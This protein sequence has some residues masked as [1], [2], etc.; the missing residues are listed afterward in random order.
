MARPR[1]DG[2]ALPAT[3]RER[4]TNLSIGRLKPEARP[5]LC[6]DTE[7]R[8]FAVSVQPTGSMSYKVIYSWRG[9]ARWYSIGLVANIPLADARKIAYGVLLQVANGID[10]AAVRKAGKKGE[11]FAELVDGYRVYAAARNKSAAQTDKKYVVRFLLPEFGSK[12]AVDITRSD[13]RDLFKKITITAPIVANSTLTECRTI[14][15]WAI[16]EEFGGIKANPAFGIELNPRN[17][18][19]RILSPKELPLFWKMFVNAIEPRGAALMLILLTGQRPGEVL[20]MHRDSIEGGWWTLERKPIPHL[21]WPGIGKSKTHRVWLGS[22]PVQEILS[23]LPATG[24]LFRSPTGSKPVD[25]L[26]AVMSKINLALNIAEPLV[27][28][29][30]L[31]RTFGSTVTGM[32]YSTEQ[33]DRLLNHSVGKK[34]TKIYDR[35]VY[36]EQN[37]KIWEVVTPRIVELTKQ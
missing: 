18:R 19:E 36:D 8:S 15:N 26:A 20:H 25:D 29:H 11:T 37:K 28:P 9:V 1:R 21:N 10:P 22:P 13:V 30:D 31:R 2:T 27:T 32:D 5:Y 23:T 24:L 17:D 7:P 14:F 34:V 35:N 4:L 3:R 16:R 12:R 6:W 33:M